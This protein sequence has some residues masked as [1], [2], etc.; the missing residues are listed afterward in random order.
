MFGRREGKKIENINFIN[1]FVVTN[2][3]GG[4]GRRGLA[5]GLRNE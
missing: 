5:D 4:G 3:R 2:E 1:N